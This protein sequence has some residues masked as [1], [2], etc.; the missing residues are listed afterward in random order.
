MTMENTMVYYKATMRHSEASF[1]SLSH[2]Q[3]DLFCRANLVFL[4][5]LLICAFLLL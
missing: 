2:M 5:V 1:M 4:A 3:Y